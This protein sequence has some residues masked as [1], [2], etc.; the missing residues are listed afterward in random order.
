[1][2]LY[3][4]WL[5]TIGSIGCI[6]SRVLPRFKPDPIAAPNWRL[7]R[8]ARE[9]TS[10][11]PGSSSLR[12]AGQNADPP[13]LCGECKTHQCVRFSERT[14]DDSKITLIPIP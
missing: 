5:T 7:Q 2:T 12:L 11:R 3:K 6:F 10:F 1:M 14:A 13:A 8:G 9:V 4:T